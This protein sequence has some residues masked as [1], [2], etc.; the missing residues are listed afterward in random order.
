VFLSEFSLTLQ[1]QHIR[2]MAHLKIDC[3]CLQYQISH[4]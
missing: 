4:T 1:L 3:Y 2:R